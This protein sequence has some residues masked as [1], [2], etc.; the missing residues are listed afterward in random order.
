MNNIVFQS[1]EYFQVMDFAQSHSVLLLRA[2]ITDENTMT[3]KNIDLLFGGVKFIQIPTHFEGGIK[4]LKG[5]ID[6]TINTSQLLKANQYFEIHNDGLIYF[7]ESYEMEL[8]ENQ[9]NTA[10]SSIDAKKYRDPT[11]FVRKGDIEDFQYYLEGLK[12]H[13]KTISNSDSWENWDIENKKEVIKI[14]CSSL[15]NIKDKTME[16][17]II[18]IDSTQSI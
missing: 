14:F 5:I 10:E 8:L 7:I 18:E 2:T 3:W 6:K 1:T 17:I 13:I 4:I 16:Q 11:N 9:L 15:F 12:N